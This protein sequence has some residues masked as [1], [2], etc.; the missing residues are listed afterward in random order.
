MNYKAITSTL[1]EIFSDGALSSSRI[2]MYWLSA[3]VS[4]LLWLI[5]RHLLTVTDVAILGVWLSSLPYLIV[6][7]I[8]LI[9]APYTVNKAGGTLSEIMQAIMSMKKG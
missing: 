8:A 3:L 1:R 7:L 5:V 9:A 6:A 4:A 2:L